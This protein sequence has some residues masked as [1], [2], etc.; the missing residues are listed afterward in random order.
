MQYESFIAN[1]L[2]TI[3]S[4]EHDAIFGAIQVATGGLSTP[5]TGAL[6]NMA[7]SC[8]DEGERYVETGVFSGYSLISAGFRNNRSVL[9]IDNFDVDGSNSSVGTPMDK[10]V[11]RGRL[12]ENLKKF[13]HVRATVVESDF[14]TVDLSDVKTGVSYI[15]ARHDYQSVTDNLKWLEPSLAKDAVLIFDDPDI[16]G[17]ADAVLDWCHNHLNYELLYMQRSRDIFHRTPAYDSTFSN[18]LAV[19]HFNGL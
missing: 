19:V 3:S 4:N 11:I 18:G 6:L 9:G 14:R 15:D 13:N 16:T 7:A 10:D 8:M 1:Y 2:R 12:L 5:R 17:V